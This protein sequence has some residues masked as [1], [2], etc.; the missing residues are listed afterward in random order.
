VV[1]SFE[2]LY[3]NSGIGTAYYALAEL[4]ARGNKVTVL[5]TRDSPPTTGSFNDW[6]KHYASKGIEL[7][8]LPPSD[9]RITNPK[10][11]VISARV[12]HYLKLHPFD[13]VHFPDFEGLGFYSTLAKRVGLGFQDTLLVAGL[14]GPTR[15]VLDAN[16]KRMPSHESELEVDYMER[17]SVENADVVW[18]PSN[19]LAS[20]LS[21]QGWNLSRGV[22]LLPLPPGPEVRGVH[23]SVHVK[24]KELVFFGRLEKRKGLMLFCDS[25]D[26]LTSMDS[27]KNGLTI[28]F[29]GTNGFVDG[30]DSSEYI[31][32]RSGRWP[33]KT[34]I[35]SNA[36]RESALEYLMDHRAARIPVCD[37]F[38]S[39]SPL[40]SPPL[41]F[42][43]SSFRSFPLSS[44]TP[45]TLSTSVCMLESLSWL[46]QLPPSFPSLPN[47]DTTCSIPSPITWPAEWC[48]Q[49]EMVSHPP[50]QCSPLTLQK[51]LG[52]L[53]IAVFDYLKL[54][55][56]LMTCPQSRFV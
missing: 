44:I 4:L 9:K 42:L 12:Y 24:A 40:F 35:I 39:L 3:L 54:P 11:Q 53:S 52:S 46:V 47:L 50:N 55:P 10:L 18:T 8:T 56:Q 29:L 6:V 20:W 43:T 2:G 22:H 7:K 17:M 5:Y 25:V 30:G 49:S 33:F 36:T 45:P 48:T 26:L 1:S 38:F 41:F 15:W 37:F 32:G 31:R 34:N 16:E 19:V 51:T 21:E 27:V 28:T 14:H 13:I 23:E